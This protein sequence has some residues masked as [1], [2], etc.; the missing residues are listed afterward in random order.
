MLDLGVLKQTSFWEI[1]FI[2]NKNNE[3]SF[4]A[5]TK[6]EVVWK[7]ER[8]LIFRE[9]RIDVSTILLFKS[10]LLLITLYLITFHEN[11]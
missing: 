3:K 10:A 7:M 11:I 9:Q 6:R 2:L 5:R 1:D 8:K 4:N